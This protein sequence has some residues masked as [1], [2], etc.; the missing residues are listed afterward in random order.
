MLKQ[1]DPVRPR[2][3]L[4]ADYPAEDLTRDRCRTT[5]LEQASL[6]ALLLPRV[7]L[8]HGASLLIERAAALTAIDVNTGTRSLRRIRMRLRQARSRAKSG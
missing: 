6:D 4:I 7:D 8:G 3:G 5:I 2:T 1:P